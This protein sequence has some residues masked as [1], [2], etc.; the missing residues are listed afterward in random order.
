MLQSLPI[1]NPSI[2]SSKNRMTT[3][4]ASS[5]VTVLVNSNENHFPPH[6]LHHH[7]SIMD[8]STSDYYSIGGSSSRS[9]DELSL[10]ET[11]TNSHYGTLKRGSNR[12]ES[13]NGGF[14][15]VLKI[16]GE[17]SSNT[18]HIPVPKDRKPFRSMSS[19]R[20]VGSQTSSSNGVCV[21]IKHRSASHSTLNHHNLSSSGASTRTK[22]TQTLLSQK[23]I[24]VHGKS[25]SVD[26]Y[27]HRVD[28]SAS[29]RSTVHS[30]TSNNNNHNSNK[31]NNNYEKQQPCTKKNP[32][33][34]IQNQ[35]QITSSS[36]QGVPPSSSIVKGYL[37]RSASASCDIGRSNKP[38]RHH[39]PF[40]S[41]YNSELSIKNPLLINSPTVSQHS[42][43]RSP[44]I[45]EENLTIYRLPGEKLGLGLRF[46]G[47]SRPEENVKRLFI[48][49]AAN[50]S[51]AKR[52]KCTWGSLEEGDEILTINSKY[53]KRMTRSDCVKALKESPVSVKMR[54]R[55]YFNQLLYS[56]SY[57]I[58]RQDT[59]ISPSCKSRSLQNQNYNSDKCNTLPSK[60]PSKPK[61]TLPDPSAL[62]R[63]SSLSSKTNTNTKKP[64]RTKVLGNAQISSR[65]ASVPALGPPK[66]FG[67]TDKHSSISSRH[68]VQTLSL[69]K[70]KET[71]ATVIEDELDEIE[72]MVDDEE[73]EISR[74]IQTLPKS[75]RWKEES[76]DT[77][78]ELKILPVLTVQDTLSNQ[79]MPSLPPQA[80]IY[81]NLLEKEDEYEHLRRYDE[82]DTT[83]TPSTINSS[84][85]SSF[86]AADYKSRMNHH[87]FDLAKVLHPFE[88]LERELTGQVHENIRPPSAFDEKQED[89]NR[90][91]I[92]SKN[93]I[94]QSINEG[95]K[96]NIEN[97]S[98]HHTILKSE[99]SNLITS[100]STKTQGVDISKEE[101]GGGRPERDNSSSILQGGM[102]DCLVSCHHNHSFSQDSSDSGSIG[103]PPSDSRLPPDGHEF[104]PDYKDPTST[105]ISGTKDDLINC[106][107]SNCSS[108][109]FRA[110]KLINTN[111]LI[112][113]HDEKSIKSVKAKIAMFQS[114]PP[115]QASNPSNK[116]EDPSSFRFDSKTRSMTNVS[117]NLKRSPVSSEEESKNKIQNRSQ[118]LLE[119]PLSS[120]S[121]HSSQKTRRRSNISKLK[122]L[123]IPESGSEVSHETK[124]ASSI[125][126]P[127]IISKDLSEAKRINL[128]TPK[129]ITTASSSTTSTTTSIM[130]STSSNI[131]TTMSTIKPTQR[132][133][134]A[135]P[136][137]QSSPTS[138]HSQYSPAFK[139]KPFSLF[140]DSPTLS[141]P[142]KARS[143][144]LKDEYSSSSSTLFE[145][146][147]DENNPRLLKRESVEAIN[148]KNILDSCKKSSG[149]TALSRKNIG[150][151]ASRS[152]SFTIAERKKSFENGSKPEN[153]RFSREIDVSRRSSS[154]VT[155]TSSR[156]SSK[157]SDI[158]L[159]G[160]PRL[161]FDDSN[162]DEVDNGNSDN[163]LDNCSHSS[164]KSDENKSVDNQEKCVNLEEEMKDIDIDENWGESKDDLNNDSNIS[165]DII[166]DSLFKLGE[167][168]C[169]NVNVL[170]T[171]SKKD[172]V[173]Y[174]GSSKL[175]PSNCINNLNPS[176]PPP[177]QNSH[178]LSKPFHPPDRKYSVPIYSNND[179]V[180]MREK[181]NDPVPSRPSSLVDTAE[182]K[183]FEVG[184]LG[185]NTNPSHVSSPIHNETIA[186]CVSKSSNNSTSSG[187]RAVSVND[188]RRA[189]EKA[190]ASLSL[191]ANTSSNSS[192]GAPSHNRMSSIDSTTS[193][194]SSIP[195]PH[196]YGS[197]SSLISGQSNL[198]DHYGSITSLASS[199]SLIS[200][201]ELQGLIDEANQ[202]LEESGTPS[203]EIMVIVLHREFTAGSIGITLA[204]GVDYE[205]KDITVHKVIPGT[206]ADRD[207]R[208]Q[209]GDRVLSINGR[210]TKGV[211]H[212]EALSILKGP[213]A[214]VVLVLSR[215]RSVTPAEYDRTDFSSYGS[216]GRPP[217][218]LE[219]PLDHKS[220]L[221]DLKFVDVPRSPP[222]T[223][224]LKKEGTG[225]G[226]SLE[227]GKDSPVGD[228]PLTIKKIF[229][230]G[231]ADK[232][233]ILKIGDEILSVNNTDCTRMS[234]IEAWNFMKKL[235][236]GMASIVVR[237]KLDNTE[238]SP[239]TPDVTEKS[240][241]NILPGSHTSEES[242]SKLEANR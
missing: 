132:S 226:F 239:P 97:N 138:H 142:P 135:P 160:N 130:T 156:R 147:M 83:G 84:T 198:K 13:S 217:K 238:H 61:R 213:R 150:K 5:G 80:E 161:S 52:A 87:Q 22:N 12:R 143:T 209:K 181:K 218:I 93:H 212:R 103:P 126:L 33:S 210:S 65:S 14:V 100:K 121:T 144:P 105:N 125:E 108:E 60:L 44:P 155:P 171:S 216:N 200:P 46:E 38:R 118:S 49:C 215:S 191:T 107:S 177:P 176:L 234:R 19:N 202:S 51:P 109:Q 9:S 184:N 205:N 117:S 24:G 62:F 110:L 211:T 189:F 77:R 225:L 175:I 37:K 240:N 169:T 180:K 166:D 229:T 146:E 224:V 190:E 82:S 31:K 79:E 68:S 11:P 48:Q 122:G 78:R 148:R 178:M 58:E 94:S 70:R 53:I 32:S 131:T 154:S 92:G 113:R 34:L 152:S 55:H 228:R 137:K 116:K 221:S 2:S 235:S 173:L 66:G 207:G 230:G 172:N 241:P 204:G 39:H 101:S 16:G 10:S 233:S 158:T 29:S 106:K 72:T 35:R 81:I 104:P 3:L 114:S 1:N 25:Y 183:V 89:Q 74:N 45:V 134:T 236:D 145:E 185:P 192:G 41:R 195:T 165:M 187:R 159:E 170:Y 7:R 40:N 43:P 20:I 95:I 112:T 163:I 17:S 120:S 18:R 129:S 203:H 98:I 8:E 220:L 64:P 90:S 136:W 167:E 157:S 139:R 127:E 227:G 115:S 57:N 96:E 179:H 182:M 199:T 242:H 188:I 119:I 194:E 123:V 223:V 231:A 54:I 149:V 124:S 237:Q 15:T 174:S 168:A 23:N 196:Y 214:E 75:Y 162:E 47:G 88:K 141:D 201:Q 50:N 86:S 28:F 6:H 206:L 76:K 232:S 69:S 73:D 102:E 59:G 208:I 21:Q 27:I 222:V 186:D 140:D 30:T 193:E 63:P 151:P 133:I 111:R 36:T 99:S 4:A 26:N 91:K 219:S 85:K 56:G 197:V 153:R 164:W 71:A 67:D 42:S 128:E